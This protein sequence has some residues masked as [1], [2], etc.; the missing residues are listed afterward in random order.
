MSRQV[1]RSRV[2][3]PFQTNLLLV[4][5]QIVTQGLS[6]GARTIAN[7]LIG[8]VAEVRSGQS[9]RPAFRSA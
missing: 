8:L 1:M 3:A 5:T 6:G 2:I 7:V 4:V 9:P